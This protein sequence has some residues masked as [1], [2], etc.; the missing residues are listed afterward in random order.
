MA[1]K[2][3]RTASIGCTR[4]ESLLVGRARHGVGISAPSRNQV[5]RD[6]E[7]A[8]GVNRL[9]SFCP[10]VAP[11]GSRL[12]LQRIVFG[13]FSDRLIFQVPRYE[14]ARVLSFAQSS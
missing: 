8:M 5:S 13:M 9:P 14:K 11:S 4:L 12:Q 7:N 10:S 3:F 2:P 6:V 1:A